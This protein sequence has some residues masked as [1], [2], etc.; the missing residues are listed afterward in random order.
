MGDW[1]FTV[2]D[3]LSKE[4]VGMAMSILDRYLSSGK[5]KSSYAL[6]CTQAF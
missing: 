1:C 3:A 5:G 2:V 4:M 6:T